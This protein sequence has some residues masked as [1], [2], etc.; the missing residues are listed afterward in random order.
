VEV[1][2][3]EADM[4]AIREIVLGVL[5]AGIV[6]IPSACTDRSYVVDVSP[7]PGKLS[8]ARIDGLEKS[9][10]LSVIDQVAQSDSLSFDLGAIQGSKNFYFMLNNIGASFVTN[11]RLTMA[12]SLFT[13]YPASIDT[14]FANPTFQFDRIKIIRV[15]AIHGTPLTG[16]GF[17][18]LMPPGFNTGSLTITA[19]TLDKS[20]GIVARVRVYA[21]LMEVTFFDGARAIDLGRP[22]CSVLTGGRNY[23][24]FIYCWYIHD[25]LRAQNTGNARVA[26]TDIG[27]NVTDTLKVGEVYLFDPNH[28]GYSAGLDGMGVVSDNARFPKLTDGKTYFSFFR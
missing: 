20:L 17:P 25:T 1:L 22:E 23:G 6:L 24:T 10:S 11:V 26:L 19:N 12:E 5:L 8:L 4:H 27:V 13:V 3:N 15:S 7:S 28:G 18:P 9:T 14:L 16:V 21:L 2:V